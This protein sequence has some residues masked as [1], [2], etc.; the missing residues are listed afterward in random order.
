MAEAKAAGAAKQGRQG[1]FFYGWW[2]V[3]GGFLIMSTCYTVFVNCIPL[4]QTHI[5]EELGITV[6]QFNTGVSIT[7]VVAVFAS[8]VIGRLTDKCSARVLGRPRCLPARWCWWAFV[9]HGG[10]AAVRAVHHCGHGGGGR[11]RAFWCRCSSRT[12]SRSSAAW[13]CPSR[14][15]GRAWAGIVLSPVTSAMIVSSGWRAAFLVL[16]VICLVASLPLAVL[17]FRTRPSDKGLEP[18]GAGQLEQAKADRS[19]MRRDGGHRLEGAAYKRVL[20]D[21]RRR[22]HHDGHHERAPSSRTPSPT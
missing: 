13:P 21:A 14:S 6:G 9:H 8:L 10:V 22:V 15:R 18:Y 12:G 16:A 5:V 19:P 4:F 17:T 7:T 3:A 20:L 1:R 2:I 11:A